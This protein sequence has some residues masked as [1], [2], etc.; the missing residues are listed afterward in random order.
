MLLW[1]EEVEFQIFQW[2]LTNLGWKMKTKIYAPLLKKKIIRKI[3]IATKR[4]IERK[5][6]VNGMA[7]PVPFTK[8]FHSICLPAVADIFYIL[9]LSDST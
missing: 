8:N 6:L 3:Y 4:Q 9:F 7:C 1:V 2:E 5:L